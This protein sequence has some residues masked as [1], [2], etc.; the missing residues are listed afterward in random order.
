VALHDPLTGCGNRLLMDERLNN[1]IARAKRN[2][3]AF[4]LLS[5]D[6]DDFKPVNDEYG[7][8]TGDIVLKEVVARLQASIRESDLLVRTGGDEFLIIFSSAVNA[9]TICQK[10]A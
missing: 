9:D 4:S 5:I 1:Q 8:Q 3:E 6:L 2:N 10:L 7:H